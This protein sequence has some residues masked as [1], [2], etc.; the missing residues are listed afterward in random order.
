MET[1]KRETAALGTEDIGSLLKRLAAPT[2]AAQL[3][4]L[5]YHVVDRAYIG[6][7]AVTGKLALAGVGVCLPLIL[8]ISAFAALVSMGAA[9]RAA[10]YL[11]KGDKQSA[12]KTLGSSFLLL[13]VIGV[14]LTAVFSRW[15]E[16]M[17]LA[18]GASENTIEYAL[19]YMR[20]YAL[21]TVFV[22]LAIGLN[23]FIAAQGFAKTSMQTVL[24]GAVLNSVLDPVFIFALD[25]GVRGAALA[26]LL[27]QAV[28]A[29]WTLRFLTGSRT[30][31]H[32]R[33]DCLKLEWPIVGPSL[34]LGLAPFI[35][36]ATESVLCVCYN[37]SLLRYGGDIAVGAMTALSIFSQLVM[38][39]L[40]GLAQGAQTII[41]FNFGTKNA[42]RVRRAFSLLLKCCVVYSV[43]LWTFGALFPQL[44]ARIFNPDPEFVAFTAHALRIYMAAAGF[45]GVQIACQQTFIAFGQAKSAVSAAILRKVVLLIPL[46]YILPRLGLPLPH[47]DAVFLAEPVADV[48]SV[49]Y[50]TILFTFVFRRSL[51]S[52]G[53]EKLAERDRQRALRAEHKALGYKNWEGHRS[54]FYEKLLCP[55][56]R[57][58]TKPVRTEW[59]E[60]Y[61]GRPAVF[62]ANHDRAYGPIA[63]MGWFDQRETLRPWINAQMLSARQAPAY[64]RRDYWWDPNGRWARLK[65]YTLAY[66]AALFLPPI[67]RGSDC[68]PVYHD[69]RVL[70]TLKRSVRAFAENKNILLFPEHPTGFLTY[71]KEV[72]PGFVSIGRLSWARLK[73]QVSFYPVHID[74]GG[75]I[76]HVGPPIVYDPAVSYAEQCKT[77]AETVEKFYESFGV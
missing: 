17:L 19:G 39:P 22:Q 52:I 33:A 47:T 44:F 71:A 41:S 57:A 50:T 53:D 66:L 23:A 76:I 34:A 28:S 32:I 20:I 3:I 30:T 68:I 43:V 12:E 46:I 55:A 1:V 51:R 13:I 4:N 48:L 7:I 31:L 54:F 5:L 26:T 61:D 69:A 58:V 16:P 25:M 37:A 56:V 62:V 10:I 15:A 40:M 42:P 45:F 36:Q 38:L 35:M 60:P 75:Q 70:K 21:G 77:A 14:V 63:M 18:I 64:I 65:D 49:T 24:I 27:S 59:E 73:K 72:D 6:H 11:G 74:W 2:I 29:A 67:L 8:I 9:P